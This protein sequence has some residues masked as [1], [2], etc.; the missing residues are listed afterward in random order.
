MRASRRFK[1]AEGT[2]SGISTPYKLF[3]ILLIAAIL[4]IWLLAWF[5]IAKFDKRTAKTIMRGVQNE[6][7]EKT[8]K[9]ITYKRVASEIEGG[10]TYKLYA[11]GEEYAKVN[12]NPLAEKGFLNMGTY[13]LGEVKGL[14]KLVFRAIEG[15]DVT[16]DGRALSELIPSGSSILLPGLER[17]AMHPTNSTVVVPIYN[18]YELDGLFEKPLIKL[19]EH[20]P[21]Y[22]GEENLLVYEVDDK[23]ASEIE[24]WIVDFSKRYSLYTVDERGFAAIKNDILF[25]SPIYNNLKTGEYHWFPKVNSVSFSEFAVSEFVKYTDK[26]Y[27]VR[28]NYSMHVVSYHY[29]SDYPTDLIYFLYKDGSNWQVIEIKVN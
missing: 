13:A 3:L 28:L 23:T 9:D 6:Y 2:S 19:A 8:G 16:V 24:N 10:I 11:D 15:A 1:R 12:L 4:V 22:Y 17:L 29:T 21:V 5:S 25:T 20:I 7:S 26:I 27:S 14:Q 18:K